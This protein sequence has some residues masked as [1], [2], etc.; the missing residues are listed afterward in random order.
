MT[1]A[2]AHYAH[3]SI[4]HCKERQS[5]TRVAS[6]HNF[7]T[8]TLQYTTCYAKKQEQIY[9][10]AQTIILES[11]PHTNRK[12][13]SEGGLRLQSLGLGRVW[14]FFRYRCRSCCC[15]VVARSS[16]CLP[17]RPFARPPVRLP[18]RLPT[19]YRS[20]GRGGPQVP[21]CWDKGR[22]GGASSPHLLGHREGEGEQLQSMS[23]E[24]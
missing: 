15:R 4:P 16:A 21:I 13:T 23:V 12:H 11:K 6:D 9:L 1:V 7:N 14:T 24:A 10:Q 22:W 18:V 8:Q 19:Q 3:L 5:T 17:I 2:H 20:T